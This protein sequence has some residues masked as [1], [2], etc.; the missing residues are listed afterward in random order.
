MLELNRQLDLKGIYVRKCRNRFEIIKE[1]LEV[2]GN[3]CKKTGIMYG[4]SLN[5]LQF[6]KYVKILIQNNFIDYVVEKKL[7]QIT[8]KGIDLLE[9]TSEFSQIYEDLSISEKKLLR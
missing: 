3:G 1:I 5:S 9:R 7:Y 6:K 2:S 8:E 4:A